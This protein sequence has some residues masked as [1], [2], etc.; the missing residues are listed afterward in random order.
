MRVVRP[1]S[2]HLPVPDLGYRWHMANKFGKVASENRGGRVRWMISARVDGQRVRLYSGLTAHGDR[3]TF[4][5]EATARAFL[6]SIRAD[7]RHGRTEEQ[8]VAPYL[9]RRS[10][11]NLVPARWEAFVAARRKRRERKPISDE[12]LR[13]LARMVDRG[14][15]DYFAEASI[16]EVS[17]PLLEQWLDWMVERWPDHTPKTRHHIVHDFMTFLRALERSGDITGVPRMPEL[18]RLETRR[19]PVPS[20]DVLGRYLDAIE[21][22]IR[23]LWLARSLDGL[24]PSE[25]RRADVGWYDFATQVLHIRES[26][27][28]AGKRAMKVH[29]DVVAWLER[30][31]PKSD[32]L[33]PDRPLFSNP[34]A[35]DGRWRPD[36]E[37]RIHLAACRA[38]GLERGTPGYFPPNHAGRHAAATHLLAATDGNVGMVQR[39]LGHTDPKTTGTYTDPQVVDLGRVVELRPDRARRS[40]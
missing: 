2:A 16:W 10:P 30:F 37:E 18:P 7:I 17:S 19:R 28:E 9:F 32:R 26:K 31:V 21:E 6:E 11:G 25:A 3:V 1:S 39:K 14:Y 12:R 15:L 33:R 40:S 29:P 24:R 8:A 38:I 36:A 13:D 23:G 35:R 27:T 34:R 4:D 22:P 5:S 20:L